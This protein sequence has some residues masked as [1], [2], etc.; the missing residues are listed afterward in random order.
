MFHFFANA[1]RRWRA[2]PPAACR[3]LTTATSTTT[4]KDALR[5]LLRET[6]QPVAVV[7]SLLPIDGDDQ[8]PST[9]HFHGAT[10]SSFSSIA[11]DPHPLIA[12][13][14]KIP[15]RMAKSLKTSMSDPAQS[16]MVLNLLSSGQAGTAAVFARPDLHPKPFELVQYTLSQDG[17]PILS[18]SLG[19]LSCS[20]LKCIPLHTLYETVEDEHTGS[21]NGLVSELFISRVQRVDAFSRDLLPLLYHRRRYTTIEGR[22][23]K[24]LLVDALNRIADYG[25][26]NR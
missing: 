21:T 17:L 6:G 25:T 1:G 10:L 23:S 19:A 9:T 7:T 12:F 24:S 8:H 16:A 20:V 13:S 26:A 15:S 2:R 11:L 18:G 5:A 4:T 22:D 3:A 14:L